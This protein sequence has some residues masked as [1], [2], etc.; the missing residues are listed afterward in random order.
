MLGYGGTDK[1]SDVSQY[2]VWNMAPH[3]AKILEH[4]GIDKV[5]GVGHD[6]CAVFSVDG[7][8]FETNNDS[9]GSLALAM[10][11]NLYPERLSALVFMSVAYSKPG[12]FDLG[13]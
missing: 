4:E 13:I 11:A 9:R 6:W 12:P 7:T 2:S 3:V 1:P 10:V 8:A 5:I